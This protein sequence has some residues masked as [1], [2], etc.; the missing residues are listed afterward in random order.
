M[1]V[2]RFLILFLLLGIMG[3]HSNPQRQESGKQFSA[4]KQAQ[5]KVERMSEELGLTEQQQKELTDW[6]TGVFRKRRQNTAGKKPDRAALRSEMKKIREEEGTR[7]REI[8]TEEQYA[9]FCQK[10]AARRKERRSRNERHPG[11]PAGG[12]P[13]R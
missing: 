5:Q 12:W 3:C 6:Y 11:G 8:L 10:E 13:G 2:F 1:T 4:E 7:L 9:T